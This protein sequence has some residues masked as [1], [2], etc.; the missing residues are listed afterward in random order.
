M[1]A[2]RLSKQ[3]VIAW[4][5]GGTRFAL[6][7]V[8][9]SL[10]FLTVNAAATNEIAIVTFVELLFDIVDFCHATGSTT[11]GGGCLSTCAAHLNF[12][13]TFR[14]DS[15]YGEAVFYCYCRSHHLRES[16]ARFKKFECKMK[17]R[18]GLLLISSLVEC[19]ISHAWVS[20]AVL[21]VLRFDS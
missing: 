14:R 20:W 19:R 5:V 11:H 8:L 1:A 15:N 18:A 13:L 12:P 7:F 17:E 3:D 10:F 9:R 21:V 6:S 4:H 2:L 16:S